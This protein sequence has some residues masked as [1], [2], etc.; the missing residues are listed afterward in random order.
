SP[1]ERVALARLLLDRRARD[2]RFVALVRAYPEAFHPHLDDVLAWPDEHKR[3]LR[4][5]DWRRWSA[6]ARGAPDSFV[7]ALGRSLES[8]EH[9]TYDAR[10]VELRL[11]AAVET[12]HALLR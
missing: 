8:A 1:E 11:L 12:P 10:G 3:L 6:I 5:L 4:E 2:P 9:P 7:D